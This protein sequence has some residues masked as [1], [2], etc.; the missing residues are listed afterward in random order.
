MARLA[1]VGLVAVVGMLAAVQVHDTHAPRPLD[2]APLG[3]PGPAAVSFDSLLSPVQLLAAVQPPPGSVALHAKPA[4]APDGGRPPMLPDAIEE[5]T[6]AVWWSTDMSPSAVFAWFRAHPPAGMKLS[7]WGSTSAGA[8]LGF[9]PLRAAAG[10]SKADVYLETFPTAD[11]RTGV[12]ASAV[13]VYQPVRTAQEMAPRAARLVVDELPAGGGRKGASVVVTDPARIA[14]VTGI[15][16]AMP[17][18]TGSFACPADNG[19]GIRLTFESA[20]GAVLA[21]ADLSSTG[22]GNAS[23]TI[24]STREPGLAGSESAIPQIQ[25]V[26]GTHWKLGFPAFG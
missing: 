6:G 17:L 22:C 9:A 18:T 25:S 23:L 14:S 24:G 5:K 13:I 11:G 12:Q 20:D 10:I 7:T 19:S 21:V 2:A 16:N 8:L 26:I 1:A 15:F 3:N 4:D